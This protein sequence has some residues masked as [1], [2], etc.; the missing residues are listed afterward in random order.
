MSK[1]PGLI[2]V[3]I[4]SMLAL[5]LGGCYFPAPAPPPVVVEKQ[6]LPPP[7]SP[8]PFECAQNTPDLFVSASLGPR[9][10]AQEQVIHIDARGFEPNELLPIVAIDGRGP[11]HGSRMERQNA[12]ADANG[13]FKTSESVPLD[14]PGMRWQVQIFRSDGVV[15]SNFVVTQ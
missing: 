6:I 7:E 9:L 14:E 2:A 3:A 1:I 10:S 12:S 4:L 11:T 8:T 15:C 13:N 5:G